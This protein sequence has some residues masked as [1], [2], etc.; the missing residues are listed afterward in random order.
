M[1]VNIKEKNENVVEIVSA[2]PY[3]TIVDISHT[4]RIIDSERNS[5]N[6]VIETNNYILNSGIISRVEFLKL[7]SKGLLVGIFIT[8]F[9]YET[10]EMT[11]KDLL[12]YILLS[13]IAIG[14]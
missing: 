6:K 1:D 7:S 2:P 14:K 9:I 4:D 13:I 12:Y 8:L 11:R 10:D 5:R 3:A